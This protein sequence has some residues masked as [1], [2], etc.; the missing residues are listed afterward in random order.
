MEKKLRKTSWRTGQFLF[1]CLSR[2]N[3]IIAHLT[4]VLTI[5]F[6]DAA[7]HFV[8]WNYINNKQYQ[9][10]KPNRRYKS[11]NGRTWTSEYIRCWIR[12]PRGASILRRP[13]TSTLSPTSRLGKQHDPQSRP[14]RKNGF[15]IGMKH[16]SQHVAQRKVVWVNE[17]VVTTM[18]SA[19]RCQQTRLLKHLWHQLCQ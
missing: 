19:E 1:L 7:F 10:H 8:K 16:I 4:I 15:T 6:D 11:K 5:V 2:N 9:F 13:P 3:S 17:I 12:C 18:K 14:V